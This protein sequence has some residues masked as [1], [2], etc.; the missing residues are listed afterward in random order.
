MAPCRSICRPRTSSTS[1]CPP[2]WPTCS[3]STGSN[4]H[5]LVLEV[6]ETTTAKDVVAAHK[7]LSGLAELGCR[8]A[9]D[10]FG[11][12]YATM[13]S[14]RAGSPVNEIKID[15]GFIRTSPPPSVTIGWRQPSSRSPTPGTAR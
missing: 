5:E 13:E 6:T 15:R 4:R 3:P 10:D 9:M 14:L 7:V 8:I 11:S 2:T 12:G 1:A